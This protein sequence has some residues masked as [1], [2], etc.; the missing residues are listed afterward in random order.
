MQKWMSYWI[1]LL[2][3]SGFSSRAAAVKDR[4]TEQVKAY[5]ESTWDVLVRD[6]NQ[7]D[8]SHADDK[9]NST[10]TILYVSRRENLQHIKNRVAG[11]SKSAKK[12]VIIRTLPEDVSHIQEH[13]LLYLPHP[14]VVPGGRFNEMYGWDSYFIQLG[15]LESGRLQLARCMVDN[16]IY[17]INH[18]GTILNANR[19]YY[20]QRSQP[21]LLTGMILAYYR[22]THDKQWLENTLPAINTFYQF[23]VSPPHLNAETGLSRYYAQG[24][25]PAPEESE[26]YYQNVLRYF[27]THNIRD[28]DKSLYYD[29]NRGT[30]TPA[31]YLADRTVRESGL[32]I[33]NKYGPFGAAIVDYIPVDLNVFLY[34]MEKETG[35]IYTLLNRS[36]S[37]SVWQKRAS[38]RAARINQYLWDNQRGFYFDYNHKTK[39]L[40]PYLFATTLYPLWAGLATKEQAKAVV[41]NLPLLMGKGGLLASPYKQGVQWDAPFGW[42]PMHYFAVE[43][44]KRYGYRSEALDL[45]QRFVNTVNKGF[46][47]TQAVFEKYDVLDE[48]IHTSGKIHYSY[49]SNEVGFGWTNG[50]YLLFLNELDA[51]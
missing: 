49:T 32:D 26:T 37:A 24:E 40:R 33:S 41:R 21:P 9:L 31:F 7:L 16:L 51:A 6:T 30:L 45:A 25:G 43:G 18:Y 36:K 23:W 20:L 14:Y 47:K 12:P 38:Q 5:V 2:L 27:K 35:E 1:I 22:R 29:A 42:A 8:W 39:Q 19:T 3:I 15:L 10:Q 13:G 48:S 17:E 44:L 4:M 28:Y 34:Q 46:A 11:T 50:V